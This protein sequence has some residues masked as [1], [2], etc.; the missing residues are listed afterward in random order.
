M[1]FDTLKVQK[2]SVEIWKLLSA[3]RTEFENFNKVVG[4]IQ[5]KIDDAGK[6]FDNLVG[7]RT[8]KLASKLKSVEVL[9]QPEAD[10]ILGLPDVTTQ[11]EE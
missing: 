4:K 5:S 10:V 7:I 3:V 1:G 6:E 9:S 11:T 2:K 8:R